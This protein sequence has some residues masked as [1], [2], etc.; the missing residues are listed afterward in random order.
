MIT[1]IIKHYIFAIPGKL[2]IYLRNK[3]IGY[4]VLGQSVT[5]WENGWIE[6][7][8]RMIINE[9]TSI[10]RNFFINARGGLSIGKNVL[11]GPYVIIY[12][13]NHIYSD[14]SIPINEQGQTEEAVIIE[15]D[16]WIG[17]KAIILPGVNIG[18]GSI[19]AA[20]AVVTKD[21]PPYSIVGGI[22]AKIIRNR[23]V[24]NKL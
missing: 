19:V 20:G 21:V 6:F 18:K 24:D 12:T 15:D 2:G 23:K 7:P 14:I 16:V 13:T 11:I 17:A 4:K 8:N 9:K 1:R 22:P 3:L 5:L 10:N